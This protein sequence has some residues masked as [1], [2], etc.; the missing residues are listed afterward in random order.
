MHRNPVKRGLV[1]EPEQ[2]RWSTFR[3]YWRKEQGLVKVNDDSVIEDAH[4]NSGSIDGVGTRPLEEQQGAGHPRIGYDL[5]LGGVDE[6]GHNPPP[7]NLRNSQ[8]GVR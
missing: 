4:S 5:K 2:W 1:L 6:V 7:M 3:W 8:D